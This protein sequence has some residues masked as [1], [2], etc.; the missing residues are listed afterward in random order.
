MARTHLPVSLLAFFI[1]LLLFPGCKS[2]KSTDNSTG[3]LYD[4]VI[5]IHFT[6][7]ETSLFDITGV[8]E[9]TTEGSKV[10]FDGTYQIGQLTYNDI[11]FY[12]TL[13]GN[14]V[15]MNTDSCRV[16]YVFNDTTVTEDIRW[17]LPPFKVSFGSGS[18]GGDISLVK[19]PMEYHESGTF[20]FTVTRKD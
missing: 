12:G 1:M 5:Q 15:T 9:V 17:V 20:S 11:V 8:V 2:N 19:H 14:E 10:K 16:T 4:I 18:G 7:P 13:N 3:D 6:Y